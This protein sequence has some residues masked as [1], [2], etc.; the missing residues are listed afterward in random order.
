VAKNISPERM[1][2]SLELIGSAL[3][4]QARTVR[5]RHPGAQGA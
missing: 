5:P 4:E 1:Q 3:Y 2:V